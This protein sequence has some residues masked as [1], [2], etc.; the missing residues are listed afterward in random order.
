MHPHVSGGWHHSGG[1]GGHHG[2]HIPFSAFSGWG[3]QY[4]QY[5]VIQVEQPAPTWLYVA[6]GA[7]AGILLALITRGR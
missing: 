4:P 6:G 7:L 1:H 3:W 2:G 5:E